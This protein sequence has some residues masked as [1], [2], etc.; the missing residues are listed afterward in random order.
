MSST[1][2]VDNML[3][4]AMRSDGGGQSNLNAL[5]DNSH[6]KIGAH[7]D[8]A[9]K[10]AAFCNLQMNGKEVF[11]WAVRGVPLVGCLNGDPEIVIYLSTR[12]AFPRSSCISFEI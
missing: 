1:S 2:E 11:K 12:R 5:F 8:D 7:G 3:G 10:H 9:S 6:S 4:M